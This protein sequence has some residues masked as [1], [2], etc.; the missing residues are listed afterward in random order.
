PPA[1][2]SRQRRLDQTLGP[3]ISDFRAAV[4]S[5]EEQPALLA[6]R[7]NTNEV[8]GA[9]GRSAS[10]QQGATRPLGGAG[11]LIPTH[12]LGRFNL[13]HTGRE[14]LQQLCHVLVSHVPRKPINARSEPELP[15]LQCQPRYIHTVTS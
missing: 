9:V 13:A 12:D 3:R 2:P 8:L 15:A 6:T 4:I 14:D 1:Q 11:Q 7:R 5:T 10:K